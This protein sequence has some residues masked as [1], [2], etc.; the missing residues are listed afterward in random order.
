MARTPRNPNVE[1]VAGMPFDKDDVSP[2]PQS[3]RR[4]R[5]VGAGAGAAAAGAQP[6]A[7]A[8]TPP[9]AREEYP[10]PQTAS[11]GSRVEPGRPRPTKPRD[12]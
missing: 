7:P 3:V 11:S 8:K 2:M 12:R 9:P 10:G 1:R 5:E 6:Q 4:A